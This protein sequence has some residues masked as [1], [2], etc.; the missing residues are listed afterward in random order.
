MTTETAIARPAPRANYAQLAKWR[1]QLAPRLVVAFDAGLKRAKR[2]KWAG[3]IRSWADVDAV[4]HGCY[5]DE[6]EGELH[7]EFMEMCRLS[8]GRWDDAPLTLIP[9]QYYDLFM[10]LF[11]WKRGNGKRRFR[12]AYVEVAKKNGKST[13]CAALELDLL[14]MAREGAPEVYTAATARKQAKIILEEAFRMVQ[15]TDELNAVLKISR[16]INQITYPANNGKL[17]ALSAD[18][19]ISEGLNISGAVIDELHAHKS[20]K[21]FDTLTYGGKSREEPLSIVITTA[22]VYDE[23]SIGWEQ[24]QYAENIIKGSIGGGFD[25]PEFLALIYAADKND[26]WTAP[27]TWRKA[28]PSLGYT[29]SEEDFAE[30]VR[31]AINDPRKQLAFKRYRLNIWVQTADSWMNMQKWLACKDSFHVDDLRGRRCYGGLDLSSTQDTTAF[32]LVF[33][34]TAADPFMRCATWFWLPRENLDEF[35]RQNNATYIRWAEDGWI[36]GTD[37]EIVDLNYIERFILDARERYDIQEIGYDPHRSPGLV[38]NLESAGV[39]MVKL[40]QGPL[41]FNPMMD[42]LQSAVYNRTLLHDNNPVMNW[43][44]G[45]VIVRYD[46]NANI[47]PNKKERRRKIDGPVSLIMAMGRADVNLKAVEFDASG[48]VVI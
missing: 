38:Q 41:T 17:E 18:V 13:S 5:F 27:G 20:R 3:W 40:I 43:Q 14:I 15:K 2:E 48:V 34:P 21:L 39:T 11:G 47:A 1:A 10:P 30:D 6:F 7:V 33:L 45:N 4:A 22:G 37:G 24:H 36:I 32:S 16:S 29:L 35:G 19:E 42:A 44:M 25:A 26:D 28:N 31:E 9:W 8:Q 46:V 23:E 12:R